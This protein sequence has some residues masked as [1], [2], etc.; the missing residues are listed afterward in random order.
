ERFDDQGIAWAFDTETDQFEKT[1]IED[2]ALINHQTAA[3]DLQL[4]SVVWVFVLGDSEVVTG[5]GPFI[6]V[7]RPIVGLFAILCRN[8][9]GVVE[10][11]DLSSADQTRDLGGDCRG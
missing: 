11:R 4:R 8:Y 9:P 10:F 3:I 6:D 1:R 2:F 5:A 7:L